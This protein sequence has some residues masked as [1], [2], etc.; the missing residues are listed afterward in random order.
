MTSKSVSFPIQAV[1][2]EGEL[3]LTCSSGDLEH[4]VWTE[5]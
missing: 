4:W 1:R 5:N 2:A 3:S